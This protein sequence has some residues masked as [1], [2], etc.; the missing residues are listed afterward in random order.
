MTAPAL[1]HEAALI[2]EIE[3]EADAAL[4]AVPAHLRVKRRPAPAGSTRLLFSH[5]PATPDTRKA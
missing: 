1:D 3:H 5:R 4:A 2:R